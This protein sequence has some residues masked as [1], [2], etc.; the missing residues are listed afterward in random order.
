[1]TRTVTV[2]IPVRDGGALLEA[3]LEAVAGQWLPATTSLEVLVCDSG[4]RDRSREVAEAAG[5]EVFT[6][7]P[8]AFSH[9]DTRNLLM[10]R[11]AGDHVALLTQD[12]VP[13]HDRWLAGLLGGFAI[14]DDVGLAFGPY[15]PRPDASVMV[16]RELREW[17]AGFAPGDGP[18][19]DRLPAQERDAPARALLGR[20]GYFTDA[21]GCVSRAAWREVPFR[22]VA[23]AED[24]VLAH[25]ML[26]AGYAKA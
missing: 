19:L 2:A 9:G 20:R 15:L 11:A 25:D 3:V 13:A 14:A 7:A 1:V 18:C 24:H 17:F 23:Y 22:P 16:R 12:A 10:E 4:S 26:R 5:A 21:N 6:I 8:E